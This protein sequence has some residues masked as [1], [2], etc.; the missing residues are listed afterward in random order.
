M[1][2]ALNFIVDQVG[3]SGLLLNAAILALIFGGGA[4]RRVLGIALLVVAM[5]L[6]S[7]IAALPLDATTVEF[8]AF[9]PSLRGDA[10]VVYGAGV[11]ADPTGG[12]WPTGA[13]TSRAAVGVALSKSLNV[14]LVVSGGI[15]RPDLAAE[16]LVLAEVLRLPPET[17]LE[18]KAG[19][20]AEN[21]HYVAEICDQRD[22]DSIILVTSREHTRRAVA[23]ARTAGTDVAEVIAASGGPVPVGLA[24]FI[25]GASGLSHWRPIIHE[26][27]GILWYILSGGIDPGTLLQ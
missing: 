17:V 5:P 14:P 9:P 12:M 24:D 21:A 27:V 16:A 26:Y 6:S 3:L 11:F 20:T 13:S 15:V 23:A 22:W 4:K 8:D 25:P 2:E 18:S 1:L 7:R 10:V 19:T